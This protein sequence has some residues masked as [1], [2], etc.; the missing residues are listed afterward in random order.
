MERLFAYA[1]FDWL[2]APQLIGTLGYES[3]LGNDSYAFEYA[4]S[5]LKSHPNIILSADINP[6]SGPQ[7]TAPG[8][9]IFSCFSDA[10][11]D[12]WGRTLLNRREQIEALEKGR[13]PRRLSSYDYLKG[14]DDSTRSGAFRFKEDPSGPFINT[15]ESLRVPPISTIKELIHA[16]EA[17]ERSEELNHLPEKKWLNQLISPGTSLG[18]ARPKAT[19]LGDNQQMY[20]A[21]FPSR[22]DDYDV[23]L[24][25]HLCHILAAKAGINV[26][27]T[28]V[29]QPHGKY[30]TLLSQRFDRTCEGK[31]IHFASA[32]TLLGLNDGD[33][34]STGHGYLDIVDFIIQACCHVKENLQELY[35]RVAFNIAVGNSD[36]H[37]RNH[38]FILTPQG[39]T[40][41]PAY[42]LN[43]T[44]NRYQS[45]LINRTTSQADL[46]ILL[47]SCEDYM[48]TNSE[49]SAII[50]EVVGAVR[51][52]PKTARN[53]GIA[54]RETQLFEH[55]LGPD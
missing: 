9:Q 17:I 55:R 36:D 7:Y 5:W 46:S 1:D 32:L 45:L 14:I 28:S 19:L 41:S 52:W 25:E 20:V 10:L 54:N 42:D 37:F 40:L 4:P 33:N 31:R 3:I 34:A 8:Q 26:A 13:P 18:G 12:R 38:G 11:P 30:H 39:W 22:N 35:R 6:L 24:W 27:K 44:N 29:I 50:S 51:T 23:A 43:P 47:S 21:K 16:S 2:E 15:S 48:L 49:A 53:L